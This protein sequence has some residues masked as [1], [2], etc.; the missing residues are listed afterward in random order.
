MLSGNIVFLECLVSGE[1]LSPRGIHHQDVCTVDEV[2]EFIK[3]LYST[4]VEVL[5]VAGAEQK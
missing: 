1:I 3:K 4:K 2:A 5:T